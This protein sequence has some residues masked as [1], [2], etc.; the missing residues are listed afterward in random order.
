MCVGAEQD[1]VLGIHTIERAANYY[2]ATFL[3]VPDSGHN[4]MMD[5][6]YQDTARKIHDWLVI[7]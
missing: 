3:A 6:H 2:G 5:T 4:L 7:P 1:A